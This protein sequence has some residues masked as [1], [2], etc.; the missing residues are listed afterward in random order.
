M[1]LLPGRLEV[2]VLVI[3]VVFFSFSAAAVRK[4]LASER[5]IFLLGLALRY[6][7]D[8]GD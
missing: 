6:G 8:P 4:P 1:I 7:H 3:V 2:E 5:P